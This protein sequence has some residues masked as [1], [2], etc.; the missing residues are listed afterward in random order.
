MQSEIVTVTEYS[1]RLG[2]ALRQV[3][4]AVIEGEVQKVNRSQRGMVFFELT[5]GSSLLEC[6][7]FPRDAATLERTPKPGDLVQVRVDR[8]DFYPAQGSLSII[9]SAVRLAGEG[10]LLRRRAELI[11]RLRADGFC[12]PRRRRP[13][14]RFPRAV[15]VIA[16]EGSDGMSDVIRALVDRWPPVR[17]VTCACLVQGKAA[18]MQL[19]DALARLQDHPLVD[20]IVIARGGGSVQDLVCFD[21]EGLC[22]A[23]FAC[24]VPVVCAIGHTDNNP[25]ANHVAWPAFTPSRSAEL[26]VSSAADVRR[27]IAAARE[28]LDAIPRRL[29][30]ARERVSVCVERMNCATAI[31]ARAACV[32]ETAGEVSDALSDFLAVHQRGLV[33]ARGT[34]TAVPHRAAR[35]LA[36]ERE[37]LASACGALAHTRE[38]LTHIVGDVHELGRRVRQ[39]IRRQLADHTRDYSRALSRLLRE[40][41][42]GVERR[43]VRVREQVQREGMLL[44]ERA[45]R[46]L[47]AAQRDTTHQNEL[48]AAHDFRQ[49]GWL[50]ASTADG[51]PTRSAADLTAGARIHL[52][53][54]DG[55]AQAVV[56]H[57]S[58]NPRSLAS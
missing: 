46:R 27:D 18:P 41:R 57:A 56:E 37:T 2:Y 35:E 33:H 19:I 47:D 21:D 11:A 50:L 17:I 34:F 42:A 16:G 44:I 54:H 45:R 58:H 26:V 15:G 13:L 39:G 20:V 52:H 51:K 6:K 5:D 32:R 24:E 14:P 8:P 7:V 9:V 31:A 23:L 29:D 30:G 10:E 22:R 38:Q 49:R 55:Q 12:D 1:A 40:A 36:A 53:L 25:V 43:V 4:P 48:I 28:R 3:G